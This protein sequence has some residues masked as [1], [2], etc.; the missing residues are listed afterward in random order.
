MPSVNAPVVA[1]AKATSIDWVIIALVGPLTSAKWIYSGHE[2]LLLGELAG[3]QHRAEADAEAAR[4]VADLDL[5]LG[6][7]ARRAATDRDGDVRGEN[8]RVIMVRS[9]AIGSASSE[10]RNSVVS[11]MAPGVPIRGCGSEISTVRRSRPGR[12]DIITMRSARM[13]ASSTSWVTN[14]ID[15]RRMA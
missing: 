3:L 11:A 4:P 7:R 9:P 6:V 12:G 13:T 15:M 8:L 1:A 5:L 10:A 2:P 14:R